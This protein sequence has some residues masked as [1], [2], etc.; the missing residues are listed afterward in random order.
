[1]DEIVCS[2]EFR[3]VHFVSHLH[4]SQPGHPFV[5]VEEMTDSA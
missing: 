2:P 4:L 5:G 1:M 3:F